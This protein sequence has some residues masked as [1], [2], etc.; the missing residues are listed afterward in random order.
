MS[1]AK[2]A[3]RGAKGANARL[4]AACLARVEELSPQVAALERQ[5]A[6]AAALVDAGVGAE[7]E[8]ILADV[9][10]RLA[11]KRIELGAAREDLRA[12]KAELG[13]LDRLATRAAGADAQAI[14]AE[15]LGGDPL[16]RSAE[17]IALDNAR[18]H[19]ADLDAQIRLG[20]E[21]APTPAAPAPAVAKMD[22][23]E[24]R[25]RFE[26]LRAAKAGP[27]GPKKKTL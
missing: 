26:E 21:L 24:A 16:I 17:E 5:R 19:I 11:Q 25:R 1:D 6:E 2:D 18:G 15:V 3:V 23:D 14:A 12:A 8:K 4:A 7:A 9:D 10:A 27:T 22:E 20:D 13:D